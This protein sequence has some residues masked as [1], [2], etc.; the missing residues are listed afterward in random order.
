MREAEFRRT[1]VIEE[2]EGKKTV[3]KEKTLLN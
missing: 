1:N 3:A 2:D